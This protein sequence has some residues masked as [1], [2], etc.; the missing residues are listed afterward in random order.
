MKPRLLC[1]CGAVILCLLIPASCQAHKVS[2]Q[3]ANQNKGVDISAVLKVVEEAV[4]EA[5]KNHV[6]Q[7]PPLKSVELSLNTAVAKDADGKLKFFVFTTGGGRSSEKSS[8]ITLQLSRPSESQITTQSAQEI[9]WK[10]KF[11]KAIALAQENFKSARDKFASLSNR[12]VEI[13]IAF[14]VK[15]NASVGVDTADLIPVGIEA[16]GKY[17]RSQIHTLK[18]IYGAE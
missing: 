12:T 1:A 17:E 10:T 7:F 3:K 8:T 13:E 2:E 5:E 9:K 15:W 16:G 18:L 4:T 6:D 11:A 14:T